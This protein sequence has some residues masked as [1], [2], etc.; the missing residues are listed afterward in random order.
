MKDKLFSVLMTSEELKLF[1]KF[2]KDETPEKL[3]RL[4]EAAE[5]LQFVGENHSDKGNLYKLNDGHTRMTKRYIKLK[6]PELQ[7]H[8]KNVSS[9][10]LSDPSSLV[11]S[12]KAI[13]SAS[14]IAKET[15]DI[16]GMLA[17][18]RR[19]N[20]TGYDKKYAARGLETILTRKIDADE[21]KNIVKNRAALA[22]TYESNSDGYIRNSNKGLLDDLGRRWEDAKM[23]Y[24]EA[25]DGRSL[26]K[27]AA[28]AAGATAALGLGIRA[29][30]RRKK[31]KQ[32]EDKIL[33][34]KYR[35]ED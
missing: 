29:I 19:L 5:A 18:E 28:L 16:S 9:V 20:R 27:D 13:K 33:K 26:G 31:R 23:V 2:V 24:G 17:T 30:K 21:A 25:L 1:A 10:R 3:R 15:A 12:D 34:R 22:D 14:E 6:D 7:E 32:E 35:R 4:N 8:A 11:N